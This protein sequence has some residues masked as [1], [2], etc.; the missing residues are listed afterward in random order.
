MNAT[1]ERLSKKKDAAAVSIMKFNKLRGKLPNEIFA[2]VE[3]DEDPVFYSAIFGRLGFDRHHIFF[4]ANGKDNVLK[5]RDYIYRSKE[6][7]KSGK[8]IYFVDRD[9]DGLKGMPPGDDLYVTPTYSIENI[10]VSQS[11]LQKLL[12]TRFKLAEEETINDIKSVLE[13][14]ET[15]LEQHQE[16]FAEANRLI[17]FV[18][19]KSLS[20]EKYTSGSINDSLSKFADL[21]S[22]DLTVKKIATG[23]DLLALLS[24]CREIDALEFDKLLNEFQ[25]L[26]PQT[27]WRGKF[28]Y[29][30]FR[31]FVGI[32]VE[33]RNSK[34]PSFFS[35]GGGKV[36]LDTSPNSFI[37]TLAS[38]C[39]IPDCLR[40]F[41]NVHA[42]QLASLDGYR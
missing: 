22:A 3:G 26:N 8:N 25:T 18:R 39:E 42:E 34:T 7:P 19:K 30:L 6:A 35:K 21:E 41:M 33:D 4:I 24:I 23:N 12:L 11:G 20:G 5:L 2:I 40:N 27:Q 32:L 15:L 31:R 16:A 13:K 37:G 9:F 17:H 10:A 1:P 14:F 38:L 29:Y 36:S 28:L